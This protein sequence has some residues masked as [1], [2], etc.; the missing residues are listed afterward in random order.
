MEHFNFSKFCAHIL[1]DSS[2]SSLL[3]YK[4]QNQS[5]TYKDLMES[6]IAQIEILGQSPDTFLAL[7]MES[8]YNLFVHLLAGNFTKKDLVIISKKEPEAEVLAYKKNIA[9]TNVISDY[10]L[11]VSTNTELLVS[12][13]MDRPAFYILSSGSSAPSKAIGLSLNNVYH[14]AIGIIDFFEIKSGDSTF[15]NLPHNHIGGLM[16][17]WRAFFSHS[18]VTKNEDDNY[19][20]ISLVPLQLNRFLD[21]PLKKIKLQNCRGVLI[22]GAP[23]K[24]ELKSL[25]LK[26]EVPIYETYGMSETSSLVMLNGTPLKGQTVKLDDENHFL[27]KGPTISPCAKLDNEGF[28][29]TKDI[30]V[31]NEDG[32][33]SFVKRSDVLYKSAGELID[34]FII[35]EKAKQ[36]PWISQIVVVPIAHPKWTWASALV[37]QTS[38]HTKSFENIKTHLRNE[39]HPHL[40]PKYYYEAPK[41]LILPDMKPKRFEISQWAQIQYFKDLLHYLYIPNPSAKR[42]VVFFHGFMEDHTDMIPLM[43]SHHENS[44]LFIDL[45]GHGKTDVT[46]FKSREHA[47]L[48]ISSLITFLQ[49]NL[50][51]VLYGYSMGGRIALE[52][53]TQYLKPQLLILESSHFGLLDTNEKSARFTADSKLLTKPNLNLLDFFTIWYKNAIFS[54]YNQSQNYEMDVIKKLDHYPAQWQSSLEFFS[55]GATPLLQSDILNEVADLRIIGIAGSE[56]E[57]YKNHFFDI[58]NKLP[59]FEYYEIA[60][61]GH[62]PH[63]THLSE[64]KMVLRNLI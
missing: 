57:K 40:V 29:H 25:A 23:L 53:S 14:S 49:K 10:K 18:S 28:L 47:F 32:T 8:S 64:I 2:L 34:P 45:P 1:E 7:K 22:G 9:F 50:E 35:E 55:P 43:D 15:L 11:P 54:N 61:A 12:V 52:L 62:N 42:L 59:K 4:D 21:N 56:D 19:K 48:T 39:M 27:I 30:G 38:D 51:L 26:E 5:Y 33:F 20:F 63:K 17:L 6:V 58:K 36:L 13:D 46:N 3:F 41:E 44:Y 37:Y 24:S 60:Q 16:I 31:I